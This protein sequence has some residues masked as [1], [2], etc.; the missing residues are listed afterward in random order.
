MPALGSIESLVCAR[1]TN[2]VDLRSLRTSE[3]ISSLDRYATRLTVLFGILPA[4]VRN[5][6]ECPSIKRFKPNVLLPTRPL[7]VR[8][9]TVY[10]MI[11]TEFAFRVDTIDL[12]RR[13]NFRSNH[14]KRVYTISSGYGRH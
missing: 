10:W 13:M 7:A 12:S 8:R 2:R 14:I 5:K 4:I 6:H 1:W 11:R 3:Q 9:E